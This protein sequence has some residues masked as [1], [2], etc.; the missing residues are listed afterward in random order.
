MERV[1]A[2]GQLYAYIVSLA[3][4]IATLITFGII[5]SSIFDYV[6]PMH[7]DSFR[8]GNNGRDVTS[9]ETYKASGQTLKDGS[10]SIQMSDSELR[11]AFEAARQNQI[12]SAKYSALKGIVTSG[13]VLLLA[14]I[15]FWTHLRIAKRYST[16]A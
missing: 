11:L 10:A 2:I 6:S 3:S 13:L 14:Q 4:I 9:F 12:D 5:I 8:F 15:F 7:S 1:K 16:L